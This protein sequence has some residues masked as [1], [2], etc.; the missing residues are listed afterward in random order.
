MTSLLPYITARVISAQG[1]RLVDAVPDLSTRKARIFSDNGILSDLTGLAGKGYVEKAD[2]KG[3]YVIALSSSQITVQS[4]SGS[5]SEGDSV[6][7]KVQGK[8]LIIEKIAS[9][10]SPIKPP[11]VQDA[12]ELHHRRDPETV[13]VAQG[14][15]MGTLASDR[16]GSC[17]PLVGPHT[18]APGFY[19]FDSIDK[20]LSWISNFTEPFDKKDQRFVQNEFARAP[21]VLQVIATGNE[22]VRAY[23]LPLQTADARLSYFV[24]EHLGGGP[25]DALFPD[26]L[27]PVLVDGKALLSDRIIAVD[28]LLTE[29]GGS[30]VFIPTSGNSLALGLFPSTGTTGANQ[31]CV[32]WLNI[33]MD[34]TVPL[35]IV[36]DHPP[37]LTAAALPPLVEKIQSSGQPAPE[38]SSPMPG[39]PD[40]SID[41]SILASLQAKESL[42]PRILERLG[43]NFENALYNLGEP[44]DKIDGMTPNL[45]HFLLTLKND[46]E[47]A[48]S[49]KCTTLSENALLRLNAC[50]RSFSETW[51]RCSRQLLRDL[52]SFLA[53]QS[54]FRQ[55]DSA[56]HAGTPMET[57]PKLLASQFQEW[58]IKIISLM[59]SSVVETSEQEAKVRTAAGYFTTSQNEPGKSPSL[60]T[61]DQHDA[62]I[63]E[64]AGSL[65]KLVQSITARVKTSFTEITEKI[66]GLLKTFSN[67]FADLLKEAPSSSSQPSSPAKQQEAH[68][69]LRAHIQAAAREIVLLETRQVRAISGLIE[70]TRAQSSNLLDTLDNQTA[71]REGK[72]PLETTRRLVETALQ[73]IDSLQVSAKPTAHGDVRQQIV[74]VPMNIDGEWNDVVVK[75]VRD[76]GN[77]KKRT[78]QKNIS[79]TINVAPAFLGEINVSMDYKGPGDCSIQMNF[80]NGRTLSWFEEN[81]A[82]IDNAFTKLGFRGLNMT[83]QKSAPRRPLSQSKEKPA[84]DSAI[85]III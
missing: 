79:I 57:A 24:Q 66:Q 54:P 80:D 72:L 75:F 45:K 83:M 31:L 37:I 42:L 26:G 44:G 27:M 3:T 61:A 29:N 48:L 10:A 11:I 17:I 51:E 18:P 7:V 63:R 28:S 68:L 21:V 43:I 32:Q 65:D 20:A 56:E 70:Q 73:R 16:A 60:G 64:A 6:V 12:L 84:P 23:V 30:N 77:H 19:Y 41:Q 58:S 55:A 15:F 85:D 69:R 67:Q 50:G 47:K 9:A 52:F 5:L 38:A 34:E 49:Q 13:P 33:A 71:L 78:A 53:E 76:R 82:E 40:F 4:A 8:D 46:C 59:E 22:G 25:L 1:P 14:A 35:P 39:V 81:R 36:A 62:A 74:M 2:G